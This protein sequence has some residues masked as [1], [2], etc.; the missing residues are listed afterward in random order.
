MPGSVTSIT[1]SENPCA[2]S[3]VGLHPDFYIM[4]IEVHV[5]VERDGG[6]RSS[7]VTILPRR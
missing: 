2:V 6:S 3:D 5:E 4:S 1:S 7:A